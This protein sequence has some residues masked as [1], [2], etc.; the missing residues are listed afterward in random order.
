[1]EDLPSDIVHILTNFIET[2]D[3][4]SLSL[5]NNRLQL[6]LAE[7]LHELYHKCTSEMEDEWNS[8][9]P[10]AEANAKYQYKQNKYSSS[11]PNG[12]YQCQWSGIETTYIDCSIYK[13]VTHK[14]TVEYVHNPRDVEL[15]A[16]SL[17]DKRIGYTFS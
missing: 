4:I 8:L 10:I 11:G 12:P 17:N 9:V 6:I 7:K 15:V 2:T 5:S 3:I 1:M 16:W 13:G 14:L